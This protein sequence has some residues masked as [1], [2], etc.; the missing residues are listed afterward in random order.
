[1][2]TT[3]APEERRQLPRFTASYVVETEHGPGRAENI[4][5]S[6]VLF[7]ASAFDV[8]PGSPLGFSI[9]IHSQEDPEALVRLRCYGRIVRIE[10]R[11]DGARGVAVTIDSFWI[12]ALHSKQADWVN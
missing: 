12:E 10:V 6:G 2:T 9:V 4:S 5:F 1:M 8:T 11:S 7:R 3:L